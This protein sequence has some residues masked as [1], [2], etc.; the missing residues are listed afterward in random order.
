MDYKVSIKKKAEKNLDKLPSVAAK[1]FTLLLV[2]LEKLGPV[3]ANWKNYSKL[4]AKKHH[5]HL[6]YNW[7]ACWEETEQ[8]IKIEVYYVG[9]RESAPY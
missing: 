4:G 5:C 1:K 2:E 9:S 8:G 7:V 6:L 3:R